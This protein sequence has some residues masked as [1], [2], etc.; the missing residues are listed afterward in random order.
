MK[1][2][3]YGINYSPE[4]VGIGKYTG[5][6][7]AW[8]AQNGHQVRVISALPYYPEW[9]VFGKF[10]KWIYSADTI[11]NLTIWRC[12]LF[13]PAQ[14]RTLLRI[15]HLTSFVLSSMPVLMFQIIWRPNIV[16][17]VEPTLFCAPGALLLAKLTR[18]RSI[19][20]I[21]DFEI[22]A[23]F[24]LGLVPDGLCS[25]ML[26]KITFFIESLILRNFDI[27]STI[28]VA[29]MQLARL[30]G[31]EP[32]KLRFLP[33]WSEIARF[34]TVEPSQEFLRRLGVQQ[35]KK[36]IL[37]SGNMGQ[38]QGLENVILAAQQLEDQK[39]LLFLLVG[40]GVSRSGLIKTATD[41]KLTNV[42]FS[43]LQSYED[44]PL[45]LGSATVH[46]VMQ[47]RGAA[48]LVLPSK[49]T[50]ILAIGG[51]AVITAETS[52]TLG[53]LPVHHPGIAL[54]V[55]PESVSALVNGIEVALKM[56]RRNSVAQEYAREFLD[57]EKVLSTFFN[58][59]ER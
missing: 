46:L 33:N 15:V 55:E 40:D 51:N 54:V 13:V 39:D 2:L 53:Q 30:K 43:P 4:V 26:K 11:S 6:M 1:I 28:S 8:L 23:L 44:L 17:L 10:S 12:P 37:Y 47:R 14:P 22:D 21:Q 50:N 56:P 49:L 18:A 3:I 42:I 45:L 52:T 27:V 29:M 35:N 59:L 9:R 58:E 16:L 48:D 5:E 41:L 34:Q 19:L 24:S 32:D 31:V 36:I 20:H 38:K 57:K 25:S 7:G